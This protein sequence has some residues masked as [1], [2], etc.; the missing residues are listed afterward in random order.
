MLY[1][2]SIVINLQ[3]KKM[4]NE[5]DLH[6]KLEK[7]FGKNMGVLIYIVILKNLGCDVVYL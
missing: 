4:N 5:D 7:N 3:D 2:Y 6:S 1:I